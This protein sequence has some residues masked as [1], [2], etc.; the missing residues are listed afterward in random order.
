MSEKS[1]D[2]VTVWYYRAVKEDRP[3][4]SIFKPV[5]IEATGKEEWKKTPKKPDSIRCEGTMHRKRIVSEPFT[6]EA[7]GKLPL[8]V[9]KRA[10]D[11]T[12][13]LIV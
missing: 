6:L 8:E 13:D 2:S 9:Y 1:G 10:S 4:N 3:N 5:W 7:D 11:A 12:G